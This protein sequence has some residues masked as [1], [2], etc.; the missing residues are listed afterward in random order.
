MSCFVTARTRSRALRNALLCGTTIMFCTFLAPL[1]Q[2][3]SGQ[4]HGRTPETFNLVACYQLVQREGRM[5][6]WARW[7]ERFSEAKIRTGQ[8]SEG[9]PA[10]IVELV[11]AWIADAY[12]WQATDEQV[13]QWATELGS[14]ENVPNANGLTTHQTIAIWMRR[15]SRHCDSKAQAAADGAVI[16]LGRSADD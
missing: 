16:A 5:I 15:I 10:W 11:Q 12:A 8:F 2:A 7:E 6:A 13:L 4:G 9:T 14:A 1:A 3:G